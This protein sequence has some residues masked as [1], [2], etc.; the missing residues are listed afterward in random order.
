MFIDIHVHTR[1]IPGPPRDDGSTYATPE[2]LI[3]RYEE[4]G[5]EKA[6]LLPSVSPECAFVPQS[7]Q[8]LL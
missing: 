8:K 6:V 5:V 4:I 3:K 2:Q 7:S 1:R